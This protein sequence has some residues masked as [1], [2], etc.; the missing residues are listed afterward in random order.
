MSPAFPAFNTLI[1]SL[2]NGRVQQR[3]FAV[4]FTVFNG[5]IGIG[6][7]VGSV[8]I[9]V[10]H[11]WT[12]QLMFLGDAV[13]SFA[14]GLIAL[15]VRPPS[16]QPTSPVT[17]PRSDVAADNP[18]ANGGSYRQVLAEPAL[19]RLIGINL[20]LA[21]CGYAALDSGL[22]AY[23]NIVTGVTPKVV[24]LALTVNTLAIV[25]L[26]LIVLKWLRGRRRSRT[27]AVVGAIWCVA[28]LVLGVSALPSNDL[29]RVGLVLGFAAAFGFGECFM[30]AS[31]SPLLNALAPPAARG[32]A[33]ALSGGVY[34]LAF[35]V[36]PAISAL[37]I[38]AGLGGV[39]IAGLSAG[40]LVVSFC[41]LTLSARLRPDQDIAAEPTID[42]A[43]PIVAP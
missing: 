30:A 26:Q 11:A 20:L 15:T 27:I 25:A 4:N 5:A 24:A 18:P 10:Q 23:A 32:R 8:V 42:E 38:A 1:G 6:S 13:A 31:V 22:P 37:F 2:A 3:A 39:W 36:S 28:W 21:L 7:L 41:A 43:S 17:A 34:S 35:V 14:A 29:A 9:D 19:R 12:F 40:C 33:N 16:S